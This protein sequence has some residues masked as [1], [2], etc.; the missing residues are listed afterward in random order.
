MGLH[1]VYK[2]CSF[3]FNSERHL[4]F[5][6]ESFKRSEGTSANSK[7]GDRTKAIFTKIK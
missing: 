6:D 5:A 4:L 2:K 1:L 3:Y 7:V